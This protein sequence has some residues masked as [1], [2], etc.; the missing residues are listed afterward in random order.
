M[1][2]FWNKRY[3]NGSII[4][5]LE[6]R[7]VTVRSAVTDGDTI[8]EFKMVSDNP[9]TINEP[10]SKHVVLKNKIIATGV[11]ISDEAAFALYAG[12]HDYFSRIKPHL[13]EK[14]E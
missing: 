8:I 3:A 11:K 2:L 1:L 5:H 12:L 7:R 9:E 13:K 4:K 10:R 6:N 14:A